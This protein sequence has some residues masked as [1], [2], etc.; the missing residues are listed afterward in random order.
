[1]KQPSQILFFSRPNDMW[2]HLAIAKRLQ[3]I[4]PETPLKFATFFKRTVDFLMQAG[5]AASYLP[6]VLRDIPDSDCT[7]DLL[8][9][10]EAEVVSGSDGA[11]LQLMLQAERFLP[12]SGAQAD[13]FLRSHVVMLDR[14]VNPG[15]LSIGSM[16]D[17]FVY[18][19]AGGL[20]NARDGWHFGFVGSAVPPNRAIV[21]RTPWAPWNVPVGADV[22]AALLKA[23][24]EAQAIPTERRLAYMR[25]MP[26]KGRREMRYY[27]RT[28]HDD[29]YDRAH[30]SYFAHPW[31][32]P[33]KWAAAKLLPRAMY[34]QFFMHPEP[35]Y[36][37]VAE[38][39]LTAVQAPYVYFP[40]HME[41]E[42][43]L[44]MYSPW[45][46]DQIEAARLVSQAMPAG[47]TLLIK[48]NP[49]MRGVRRPDYYRR[50]RALPNALLVD[51]GVSSGA[52]AL[53]ARATVSIAG[54]ASLEAVLMGRPGICLGRPPFRD[55]LT[56]ADFSSRLEL[57]TLFTRLRDGE[58]GGA[59]IPDIPWRR[60]VEGTADVTLSYVAYGPELAFSDDGE[61]VSEIVEFMRRAMASEETH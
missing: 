55:L 12:R 38:A 56:A 23:S 42:A 48:E 10:V 2:M 14:L 47:W 26:P 61:V 34:R 17:H 24:I 19:M 35:T 37:I 43:T 51:P 18:W 39:D 5:F 60:W 13:R 45:C 16:F 21:L 58:S 28:I 27:T 49:K 31:L 32:E 54:N 4:W 33:V 57:A 30:G 7:R 20:A 59:R 1:M 53:G 52:L 41:P 46:R 22:C 40:L 11:N 9:R 29:W 50:L 44:L 25:P 8:E 6:D 3:M 36:D 15:T